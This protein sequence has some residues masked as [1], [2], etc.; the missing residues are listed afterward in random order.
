LLRS[1]AAASREAGAI[2]TTAGAGAGGATATMT[3]TTAGA[4]TTIGIGTVTGAE[5]ATETVTAI[6]GTANK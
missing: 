2:E 1:A 4:A 6:D 5:I 3:E